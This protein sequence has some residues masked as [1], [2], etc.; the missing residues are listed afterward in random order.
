MLRRRAALIVAC[1]LLTAAAAFGF[2]KQQTKEYT[3]TASLVFDSGQFS[4]QVAGLQPVR[5]KAKTP[6]KRAPG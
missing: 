4:Q 2:S 6:A 3:A 5:P 1:T